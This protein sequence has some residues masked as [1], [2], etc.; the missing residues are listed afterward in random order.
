MRLQMY[1]Q[2]YSQIEA[3]PGPIL[4]E[5]EHVGFILAALVKNFAHS[6]DS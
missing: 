3:I 5:W 2:G 4:F 1:S 6:T